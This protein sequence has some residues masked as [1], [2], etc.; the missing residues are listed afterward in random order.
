[1]TYPAECPV[2]LSFPSGKAAQHAHDHS[3]TTAADFKNSFR[4]GFALSC[5]GIAWLHT[6]HRKAFVLPLITEDWNKCVY[7]KK[8]NLY[9]QFVGITLR[10]TSWLGGVIDYH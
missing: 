9:G 3:V 1:M 5:V 2:R 7:L 6:N 10:D 8:M 4:Y